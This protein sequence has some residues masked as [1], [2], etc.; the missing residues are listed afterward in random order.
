M[1]LYW[2]LLIS[3]CFIL[4]QASMALGLEEI[5]I[6]IMTE[7]FR[8][9]KNERF[10][11]ADCPFLVKPFRSLRAGRGPSWDTVSQVYK[12]HLDSL[13]HLLGINS[14]WQWCRTRLSCVSHFL[15]KRA[16]FYFFHFQ[17]PYLMCRANIDNTSNNNW[18]QV[19]TMSKVLS[20]LWI[21]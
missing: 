2:K 5:K 21:D 13:P 16:G 3:K 8:Q 4:S 10:S 19:F 14:Q 6:L 18:H 20:A 11:F 17:T 9:I 12:W 1:S 15:P 7:N